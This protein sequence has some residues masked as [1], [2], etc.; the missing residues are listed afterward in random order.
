MTAGP[1]D[2]E[3][4]LRLR[5]ADTEM[6]SASFVQADI[7]AAKWALGEIG[8]LSAQIKRLGEGWA[9]RGNLANVTADCMVHLSKQRDQLS[10]DVVA[11]QSAFNDGMGLSEIERIYDPALALL[12]LRSKLD[13]ARQDLQASMSREREWQKKAEGCNVA[14]H[15]A[16]EKIAALEL[17]HLEDLGRISKL[18][19]WLLGSATALLDLDARGALVP[20]GIGEHARVVIAEFV[21]AVTPQTPSADDIAAGKSNEQWDP[22]LMNQIIVA[23][24]KGGTIE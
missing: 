19:G 12:L 6:M 9:E 11:W 21:K 3:I 8:N 7:D 5:A 18:P 1:R 24:A 13:S 10:A 17:A 22:S 20:H 2:P 23:W 14:E 4:H 16:D 15:V